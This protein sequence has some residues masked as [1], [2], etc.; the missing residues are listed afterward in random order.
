MLARQ[1]LVV[2]TH[3]RFSGSPDDELAGSRQ[4]SRHHA[5]A[6]ESYEQKSAVE[7]F[8]GQ[9]LELIEGPAHPRNVPE[10]RQ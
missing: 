10:S 6:H 1:R 3:I 7:S 5:L 8:L 9:G 2:D 4:L